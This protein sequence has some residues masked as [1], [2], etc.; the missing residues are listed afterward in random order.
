MLR[1]KIREGTLELDDEKLVIR[2]TFESG[3]VDNIITRAANA[4]AKKDD[5]IMLKE[6]SMVVF[7]PGVPGR[8]CPHMLVYYREKDRLIEFCVDKEGAK[9]KSDLRRALEFLEQRGIELGI[10]VEEE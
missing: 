10:A 5:V 7:E 6:I 3:I 8:M 9:G 4:L 2:K 1:L